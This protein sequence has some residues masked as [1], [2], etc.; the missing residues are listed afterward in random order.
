MG[1]TYR[2]TRFRVLAGL[3]AAA[4]GLGFL[5]ATTGGSA[6]AAAG[7]GT[8]SGGSTGNTGSVVAPAPKTVSMLALGWNQVGNLGDVT[9]FEDVIVQHW[10]HDVAASVR[11]QSPGTDV[12]AYLEVAAVK[13]QQ[14]RFGAC[15]ATVTASISPYDD[16]VPLSYCWVLRNR[17][18]WFLRDA[19]G[20]PLRFDDFPS[21]YAMDVSNPEFRALWTSNAIALVKAGGFQGSFLDDVMIN[22]AH[23]MSGRIAGM[24]DAQYADAMIGFMQQ[25]GTS[26]RQE[27]LETSANTGADP[28]NAGDVAKAEVLA[29]S[30]GNIHREFWIRWGAYCNEPGTRFTDPVSDGNPA[31]STMLDYQRRLQA[32]GATVSAADYGHDVATG[33]DQAA[34]R[35]GRASFLLAWDGRSGSSYLYRNCGAADPAAEH[36]TREM[37]NPTGAVATQVG[38]AYQRSF[39]RGLVLVNPQAG[40]AVTIKLPKGTYKDTSGATIR[41]SVTLSPRDAALLVRQ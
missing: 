41:G 22:L 32:K 12:L 2:S 29:A 1:Q 24:T 31:L 21:L 7:A 25:V 20:Q 34:M 16:P 28:W 13:D 33:D 26:F 39:D 5:V 3:V 38:G 19:A 30:L 36:W 10:Y 11:A 35:Y 23:G 6:A 15:P 14:A 37:G 9:R 17:P 27:G 8:G 4:A 40:S 18:Q